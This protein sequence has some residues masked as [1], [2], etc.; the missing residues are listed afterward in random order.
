MDIAPLL[1]Q[2]SREHRHLCPRQVLGVRI[3]LAGLAA[4]GFPEPPP[5]RQML[6]LVETDGCF[7]DGVI[8]ATGCT[9][10]HRA[11]RIVDYGKIAATF[12]DVRL[13]RAVRVAPTWDARERASLFQP[14]E[15]RRYFAQL[16]AYQSMPDNELL[17]MQDV[18]LDIPIREIL[19]RPGTRVQCDS[20]GEEILNGRELQQDGFVLCRGCAGHVYYRLSSQVPADMPTAGPPL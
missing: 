11:L 9:V 2:S 17:S 14:E 12:V 6:V 13:E 1:E 19:S 20:C 8:A 15:P 10:G 4:L 5:K 16:Q 7:A 18:V 3:G